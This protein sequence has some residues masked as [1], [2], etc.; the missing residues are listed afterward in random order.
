MGLALRESPP[1]PRLPTLPT[2]SLAVRRRLVF[3]LR[4]GTG[5]WA[6]LNSSCDVVYEQLLHR[7]TMKL[8]CLWKQVEDAIAL[9]FVE[10]SSGGIT[11]PI[12]ARLV[13]GLRVAL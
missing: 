8:S 13:Q 3:F 5:N 7:P 6:I 4:P 1:A 9:L 2:A 11:D 12:P 10:T